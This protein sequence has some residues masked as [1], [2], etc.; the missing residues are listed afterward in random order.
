MAEQ[1]AGA[2]SALEGV[3]VLDLATFIAAPFCAGLLGELG[4]DVIKV[5]QPGAG[6]PLRD[7]G[8]KVSGQ[9]LFWALE[10]RGRRSVTC[11]LR[12]SRGQ[13]L[14]LGLVGQSDI[15]V[16]NFRPG[17]LERWSLGYDRMREVNP[18]IVLVRISAYGQTGPYA[19]RPGFGRIAQA[20]GGLTYLAG[21]PGEPPI[22]PGSA[23][24]ADYAAGLFG[25]VSALA[26]LR[27]RERT[28]EGQEIDVSLFESIFRMT[29]VMALEYDQLG[30][31]RERRGSQAHAVP[32]NHYPTSDG[33]WVAVA[34]T[35]DR[36]FRRLADAMGQSDWG[37]D[38]DF[39]RMEKRA[40]RRAEVDERVS[41]WTGRHSQAELCRLLD[42]AEVPNSPIN[43]I[44]DCFADPHYQ[45]RG[46]LMDVQDEILGTVKMH[47]PVPRLSKTAAR[48]QRAAPKT[49]QHNAEVYDE[50]LGLDAGELSRLEADGVI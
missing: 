33:R 9:G 20:F 17:T 25:A 31:I 24:L 36:L 26:A 41:A 8:P 23:T 13:E 32:H 34:C 39:D 19:P 47:A 11:N 3:R 40:A 7:L 43:S 28:G 35:N 18:G 44:A 46:T 14:V 37:T 49:G 50:L 5:E 6:D 1:T 29:D 27:H 10:A 16:E 12:V 15:V 38:P 2:S 21:Y 30:R 48:V 42:E 4:A 22:N 45:A